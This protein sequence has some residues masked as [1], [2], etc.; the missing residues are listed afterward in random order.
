MDN[1][2]F[3]KELRKPDTLLIIGNGF[4]KHCGLS[5]SFE[6]YFKSRFFFGDGSYNGPLIADNVWNLIFFYRYYANQSGG[7]I[8]RVYSDDIKWMDIEGLINDLFRT[9]KLNEKTNI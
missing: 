7:Y 1:S 9:K 6:D 3:L 2:E 8:D 5:S 4:D